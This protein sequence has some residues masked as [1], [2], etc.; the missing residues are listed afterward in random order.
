MPT[1]V[2]LVYER[3]YRTGACGLGQLPTRV[4]FS[5]VSPPIPHESKRPTTCRTSRGPVVIEV[6]GKRTHALPTR[7]L[8]VSAG[9]DVGPSATP[10][11]PAPAASWPSCA[12]I[13]DARSGTRASSRSRQS[14]AV[15]KARLIGAGRGEARRRF[16]RLWAPGRSP[17]VCQ[18]PSIDQGGTSACHTSHIHANRGGFSSVRCHTYGASES[19][20][21]GVVGAVFRGKLREFATSPQ[22]SGLRRCPHPWGNAG[23]TSADPRRPCQFSAENWSRCNTE[24]SVSAGWR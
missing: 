2:R 15:A 17:A 12:P 7:S 14:S 6:H 5:L 20:P 9:F 1:R 16:W 22:V 13:P 23:A 4:I 10:S 8:F 3:F 24:F 18:V 21:R 11:S 19:C